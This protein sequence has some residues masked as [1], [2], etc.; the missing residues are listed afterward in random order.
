MWLHIRCAGGWTN[1]L[2]EYFEQEQ[3]KRCLSDTLTRQ[4]SNYLICPNRGP[5]CLHCHD[6]LEKN[7]H[8]RKQRITRHG[9]FLNIN[10]KYFY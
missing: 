6:V 4:Q 3:A 1:K 8:S 2:Y 7:S 5:S 9:S 10:I